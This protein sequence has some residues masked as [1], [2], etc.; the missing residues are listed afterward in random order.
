MQ[1][2]LHK[3]ISLT[4]QKQGFNHFSCQLACY[5]L[6]VVDLYTILQKIYGRIELRMLGIT[7]PFVVPFQPATPPFSLG[8]N[9]K[10]PFRIV[11]IF[12]AILLLD[13]ALSIK[14][15]PTCLQVK[16]LSIFQLKILTCCKKMFQYSF[17]I[18][19]FDRIQ[20]NWAEISNIESLKNRL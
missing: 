10:C 20:R 12:P 4:F 3:Y 15:L 1:R 14:I 8:T 7:Q 18:L 6:T 9:A 5:T 17:S 19:I 13:E 2:T 16:K 11:S